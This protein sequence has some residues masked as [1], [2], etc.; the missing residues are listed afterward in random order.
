MNR[1]L[2]ATDLADFGYDRTRRP[3]IGEHVPRGPV[4]R[5]LHDVLEL[6]KSAD[7]TMNARAE[8]IAA[9]TRAA[10]KADTAESAIKAARGVIPVPMVDDKKPAWWRIEITM[11]QGVTV[12]RNVVKRPN[13]QTIMECGWLEEHPNGDQFMVSGDSIAA[14]EITGRTGPIPGGSL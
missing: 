8:Q 11:H 1:A 2:T 6:R 10:L 14:I 12:I 9:V 3:L 13:A 7:A 4:E 5:A